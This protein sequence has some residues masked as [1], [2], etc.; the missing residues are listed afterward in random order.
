MENESCRGCANWSHS[1]EKRDT[2]TAGFCNQW[3]SYDYTP[4]RG[5]KSPRYLAFVGNGVFTSA[6]DWCARF[7]NRNRPEDLP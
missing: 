4:K 6:D 1:G 2:A 7:K 5:S 3:S